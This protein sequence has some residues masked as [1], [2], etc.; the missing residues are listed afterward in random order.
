MTETLEHN[1]TPAHDTSDVSAKPR[2]L[3]RV[4]EAVRVRHYSIRTERTYIGWIRQYIR[5]NGMRHP[6]DLGAP[7]VEAFLSMLAWHD[8]RHTWASWHVQSGTPLAV[9]KTL[10]GWSSMDMV[11]RYAHLAP[12]HLSEWANNAEKT[13]PEIVTAQGGL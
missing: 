13:V 10:G 1:A 7:E 2:L 11:M 5:H 8:L 4:R 9:L 6:A 12:E 3:D